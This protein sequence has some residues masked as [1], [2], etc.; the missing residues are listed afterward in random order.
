MVKRM[1][2]G[3]QFTA[4][5]ASWAMVIFVIHINSF[6]DAFAADALRLRGGGLLVHH[7]TG[8]RGG[9]WTA[10]TAPESRVNR[11]ILDSEFMFGT[12]WVIP[13]SRRRER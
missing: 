9:G 12:P 6:N 13:S 8:V 4:G 10:N 1:V 7:H 11:A 2:I 3:G 5:M